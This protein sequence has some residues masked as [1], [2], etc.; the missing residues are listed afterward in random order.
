MEFNSD[1]SFDVVA[2]KLYAAQNSG[3]GLLVVTGAGMSVASGVPVF[4]MADGSMSSDFLRFLSDYNAARVKNGL[5]EAD[6]WFTFSVPEM[7][8]KETEAEAWQ[9]WRWRMLRALVTPADD[10]TYLNQLIEGFGTHNVFVVTSNCDMLHERSGVDSERVYEIHGS[11]GRVQC[12]TPC[13]QQ[14]FRV[15][16]K[17]LQRLRD[18]PEWVP[19]CPCCKAACLR[20]NVMIFG[21]H[22]LVDL[23]LSEQE[24]RYTEFKRHFQD[25]SFVVLEIG[26]GVV[27]SSIRH[28]AE[29]NAMTNEGCL[30]RVNP[31]AAECEQMEIGGNRLQGK[32]FPLVERSTAALETLCKKISDIEHASNC[33]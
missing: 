20:P 11:L 22:A 33:R 7:F 5:D 31:S 30:I 3:K 16:E 13:T 14:L 27:V 12:S 4:R 10:Y 8:R 21:D 6:D 2:E 9:Y 24:R 18:E 32:Y 15:D 28:I 23:H 25:G 26:A 29:R 17:F 1:Q 19:Q